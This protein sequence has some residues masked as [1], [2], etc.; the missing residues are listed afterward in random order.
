LE[1]AA[2]RDHR[3]LGREL[4]LL[5]F[6]DELGPGMT[7]FLPKGAIVRK[8]MEDWS[9]AEHL[10]RGYQLV[11]TPHLADERMWVISGHLEN[12]GELMYDAMEHEHARYRLKPM[13][14]PMHILAYQSQLRSY[15]DLPLRIAEL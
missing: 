2:K 12:Y 5:H 11:Y 7:I 8:E 10:K 15:R 14:C 9:R 3:R 4:E 6:T 13:N 1:E